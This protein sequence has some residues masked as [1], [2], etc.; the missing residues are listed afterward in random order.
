MKPTMSDVLSASAALSPEMFTLTT[1]HAS[2][3]QIGFC[4]SR[5]ELRVLVERALDAGLLTDTT[6]TFWLRYVPPEARPIVEDQ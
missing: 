1:L 3:G 6:E 4:C 5:R 2:L